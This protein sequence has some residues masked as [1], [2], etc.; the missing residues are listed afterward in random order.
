MDHGEERRQ[1]ISLDTG[2]SEFPELLQAIE[3]TGAQITIATTTARELGSVSST[4]YDGLARKI[5]PGGWGMSWGECWG[6][7]RGVEYTDHTGAKVCGIPFVEIL[8][9]VSSGG[10]KPPIDWSGLTL[11]QHRLIK[12]AEIFSVHLQH[13]GDVFVTVDYRA[14][15]DHAR[16][17]DLQERFRTR[18]LTAAE[19]MV[20]F[21]GLT[22]MESETTYGRHALARRKRVRG[23]APSAE[24]ANCSKQAPATE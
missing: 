23:G 20:E 11:R 21:A 24:I 9:V 18:I 19:A 10:I 5:G 15:I 13:G 22:T 1:R 8:R 3:R 12:D 16:R 14:F 2:C 4:V 17:E 7:G 6:G